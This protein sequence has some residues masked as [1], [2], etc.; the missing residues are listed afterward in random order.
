MA[1][2][3]YATSCYRTRDYATAVTTIESV[4]EDLGGV[5]PEEWVIDAGATLLG[6]MRSLGD[7]E[8]LRAVAHG[9]RELPGDV[10]ARSSWR[11]LALFM[12][13]RW[14]DALEL[15]DETRWA[16]RGPGA[17][18]YLGD[19][20]SMMAELGAG[21]PATFETLLADRELWPK[22][23]S[24]R[25]QLAFVQGLVTL[26]LQL[27]EV[28]RVRRLMASE[29]VD[30]GDAEPVRPA[31]LAFL[32]GRTT[33]AKDLARR[34]RVGGL[35][36]GHDAGLELTQQHHAFLLLARGDITRAREFL[37]EAIA[38]KSSLRT[39][40]RRPPCPRRRRRRGP[41]RGDGPAAELG[42]RR[43][44]ARCPHRDRGDPPPGG[45]HRHG[46]RRRRRRPAR[47][48][49]AGTSARDAGNLADG[50]VPAARALF[51]RPRRGDRRELSA[52]RPGARDPPRTGDGHRHAGRARSR[53]ARR[54]VGVL[55]PLRGARRAA[56]PQ[57]GPRPDDPRRRDRAGP[58]L[59]RAENERLLG[60]LVGQGF[61]NRTIATILQVSEKSVEGR[62]GRMFAPRDRLPSRTE[63][64]TAMQ[65]PGFSG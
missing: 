3:M 31:S 34:Y 18:S 50:A 36:V 20:I 57:L 49:G 56:V 61:G 4:L 64:M 63:L 30:P 27:S 51:R 28:D 8:G 24:A 35:V 53:G 32:E 1:R 54:P 44:G 16:W 47:G 41:R 55:R 6:S 52:A 33:E 19:T 25:R 2:W 40:A 7:I 26:L 37:D 13:G 17:N 15:L 58:G 9:R 65:D 59:G 48:R 46:S 29:G 42:R 22:D 12:L 5:L 38:A 62:L 43:G 39:S 10:A 60:L 11:A 23:N 45:A 21:R 14:R